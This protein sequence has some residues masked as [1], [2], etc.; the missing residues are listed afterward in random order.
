MATY[1]N[2]DR[3][4]FIAISFRDEGLACYDYDVLP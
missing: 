3:L 1:L 4:V 2:R